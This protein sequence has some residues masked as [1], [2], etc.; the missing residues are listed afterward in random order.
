VSPEDLDTVQRGYAAFASGDMDTLRRI[1]APDIEW[2]TT[3]DVPFLGTY[4]GVDEFFRGMN[5]FRESFGDLTTEIE[6]IVDAGEHA[7]VRLAARVGPRWTDHADARL[8]V[9]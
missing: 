7:V 4:R 5:D 2:R 9:G 3:S 6:E 1:L 8:P